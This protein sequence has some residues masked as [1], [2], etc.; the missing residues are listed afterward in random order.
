MLRMISAPARD[1]RLDRIGAVEA[2]RPEVGVVPDVLADREPQ[3][4]PAERHRRHLGRGLEVAPLVEHV[5]GRQQ[6]LARRRRDPAAVD[7][8]GAVGDGPS[9]RAGRQAL[10]ET[11]PATAVARR[12]RA[13]P[14]APAS[15]ARRRVEEAGPLEQILGRIAG[16]GQLGKDRQLGAAA[17]GRGR[18]LEHEPA[19]AVEVA[20]GRVDL[21]ERDLH[22]RHFTR[23]H[24]GDRRV[25]ARDKIQSCP[26]SH[27]EL[28]DRRPPSTSRR[29]LDRVGDAPLDIPRQHRD[30]RQPQ[31]AARQDRDGRLRHGLHAGALQPGAHRGAVDARH[32]ATSW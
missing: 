1:Q 8:R 7:Q 9:G 21:A 14:P 10:R 28:G 32:A 26:W 11:R 18:A 3:Q 5:V 6:R 17:L 25:A 15:E 12:R 30:L 19:V 31:P 27:R 24:R 4:R 16:E 29:E 23:R 20:D 22:A 13:P 2:A